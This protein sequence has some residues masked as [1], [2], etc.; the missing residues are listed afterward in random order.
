MT[1]QLSTECDYCDSIVNLKLVGQDT[2]CPNCIDICDANNQQRRAKIAIN[3]VLT[4][5]RQIDSSIQIR[6]DL[7]NAHTVAIEVLRTAIEQDDTITNKPYALALELHN[8]FIHFRDVIFEL[9]ADIVAKTNEQ[10]AIQVYLNTLSN[11][12]RA[13]ERE[14]L[15][16]S[17]INYKP[18]PPKLVRTK[19]DK[20]DKPKVV[21]AKIDKTEMREAAKEL[22]VGEFVIQMLCTAKNLTVKQAVELLK[23]SLAQLKG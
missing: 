11:K 5:S 15:K 2:V 21:K 3:E 4:K 18:T 22:G 20:S 7:F 1:T 16:L 17:D 13:E 10:Q 14:K 6:T 12:L 9:K 23:T 8:R 19:S